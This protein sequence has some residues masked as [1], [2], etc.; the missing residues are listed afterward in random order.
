MTTPDWW[1]FVL[2]GLA[3]Y[4]LSRLVGWDTVT[5]PLRIRLTRMPDTPGTR[6]V[7]PGQPRPLLA[8]FV[9]C[10]FCTSFWFSVALYAAWCAWPDAT[11]GASSVLALSAAAGL[12]AK[13]LDP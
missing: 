8:E 7:G 2:L 10:P 4:R 5:A 12:V 6:Y 13:Q 3:V 1:E 11:L 9:H